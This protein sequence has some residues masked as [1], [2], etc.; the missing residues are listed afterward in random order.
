LGDWGG[1]QPPPYV[2]LEQFGLT[3]GMRRVAED[4]CS[5]A[6]I[7]TG[8]NFYGLGGSGPSVDRIFETWA[9]VNNTAHRM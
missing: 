7:S 6:V 9:K 2:T 1:C 8:D 4:I 5:K 3:V